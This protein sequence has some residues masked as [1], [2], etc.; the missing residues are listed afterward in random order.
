[1][2]GG[3]GLVGL[4]VWSGGAVGVVWNV[5]GLVQQWEVTRSCLLCVCGEGGGCVCVCG[6]GEGMCM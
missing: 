5:V 3:H 6:R 2:G 1:M 4:W